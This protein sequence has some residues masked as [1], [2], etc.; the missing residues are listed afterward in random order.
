MILISPRRHNGHTGEFA[1]PGSQQRS[2]VAKRE[3]HAKMRTWHKER[4]Q[5]QFDARAAMSKIELVVVG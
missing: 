2:A 1:L 3:E 4:V 5:T